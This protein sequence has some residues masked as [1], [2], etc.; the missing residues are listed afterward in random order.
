MA[1]TSGAFHTANKP[2][3]SPITTNAGK[4]FPQSVVVVGL[5]M[6]QK[7]RPPV[8]S[9]REPVV[10]GNTSDVNVEQQLLGKSAGG[11]SLPA[12]PVPDIPLP[13]VPLP[14][15]PMHSSVGPE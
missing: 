15:A 8:P 1:T 3:T 7:P 11:N 12:V 4:S 6:T 10:S 13:N 9:L 14:K 2:A 5:V